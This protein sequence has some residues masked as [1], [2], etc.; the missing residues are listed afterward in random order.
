[1]YLDYDYNVVDQIIYRVF[2]NSGHI[3][4]FHNCMNMISSLTLHEIVDKFKL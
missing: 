4:I 1:M 3:S 2:D